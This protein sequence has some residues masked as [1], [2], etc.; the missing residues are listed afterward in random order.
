MGSEWRVTKMCVMGGTS[1]RLFCENVA[2]YRIYIRICIIWKLK[3]LS[4]ELL[5][6]MK[7]F[8]ENT[9]IQVYSQASSCYFRIHNFK[10]VVF[11][12]FP[13]IEVS[14]TRVF[15]RY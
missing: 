11:T 7:C 10:L 12:V 6:Y 9:L 14:S 1:S 8:M 3:S 15:T 5:F 2:D 4:C 13:E